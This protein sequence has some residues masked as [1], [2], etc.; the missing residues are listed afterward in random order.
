MAPR[1]PDK[2]NRPL[3]AAAG[4][5]GGLALGLGLVLLLELLNRA[6][7]R[8]AELTAR[9]GITPF[10]TLPYMR[11]SGQIRD[12]PRRSSVWRSLVVLVGIPLGLWAVHT[13]VMPL[14]L[15]MDRV[16]EQAWPCPDGRA[17]AP[18]FGQ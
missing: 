6:I 17:G 15:L 11:T 10:A 12:A 1:E 9:L 7:R 13:Y 16:V 8:P 18:E 2:P 4:V 3:I 5:G 14:D